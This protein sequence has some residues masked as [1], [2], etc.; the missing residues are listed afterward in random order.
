[1]KPGKMGKRK[2]NRTLELGRFRKVEKRK[3]RAEEDRYH[4]TRRN[5]NT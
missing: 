4:E 5:K 2:Q 1:M 3:L